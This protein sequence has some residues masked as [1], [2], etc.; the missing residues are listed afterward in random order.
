MTLREALDRNGN[1]GPGFHL[2][3]H[4]LALAIVLFHCRQALWWADSALLLQSQGT[5][6]VGLSRPSEFNLEDIVRPAIHSLVGIF[7]A[8]SGFL[9]AGSALRTG[10]TGRF[11]T[12]RALRIFPALGVE[13]LLSALIL[14]PVVTSL[15]LGAYFSNPEFFRYFGN[16]IGWVYYF[17]PGVFLDNPLP[18]TVNGQLWTLQPEFWCYALMAGCMAAG[19]VHKRGWL[20]IAGTFAL[21]AMTGLYLYDPVQFDAK[22]ENMFLPWY[23]V[24]LFWFGVIYYLYADR[25]PLRLWLFLA[26]GAAYWAM[27]FFN[28]VVPLAGIP[29]GYMMVYIGMTAF[30][31]WDRLVKSDYSYGIYL[32]HFPLV[33]TLIWVFAP[34]AVGDLSKP[35]QLTLLFPATMILSIMFA[36]ASWRLI[37]KP[38]L[39][40]RQVFAP[41][42]A[43]T[44]RFT[45]A[46]RQGAG[47]VIVPE[48]QV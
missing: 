6:N 10:S 28:I 37:E 20:L 25:V 17:L 4:V 40:L 9:V 33:Q 36:A 31:W 12:N 26:S 14:G 23:I 22:G 29:L 16:M 21:A 30:P 5:I 27:M 34:T 43:M 1:I 13:T 15:T 2:M 46:S 18:R 47:A 42:K 44:G 24:A 11:L 3:R 32:Y 19:I 7:F 8:L 48:E 41:T 38:A 39:G 35:L 45:T